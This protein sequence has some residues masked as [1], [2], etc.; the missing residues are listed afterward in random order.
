MLWILIAL[1]VIVSFAIQG[2][3]AQE[4][5]KPY[6]R[7]QEDLA[8]QCSIECLEEF[9][10]YGKE[11]R[12]CFFDCTDKRINECPPLPEFEIKYDFAPER[13]ISE[14]IEQEKEGMTDEDAKYLRE[15]M[16]QLKREEQLRAEFSVLIP[17][18]LGL[19]GIGVLI[20]VI[21][22]RRR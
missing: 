17:V 8:E 13:S 5:G 9:G 6:S 7:C 16:E 3:Y 20:M 1:T 14:S 4:E 22:H 18:I 19:I 15:T 10:D 21:K 11:Y 12:K 2:I